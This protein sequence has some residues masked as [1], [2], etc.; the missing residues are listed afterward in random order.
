MVLR[1]A[2]VVALLA[3]FAVAPAVYRRRQARLQRGPDS[4]PPVPSALREGAA[5]TWVV[6]TTPWCASCGPVEARLRASDPDARVV[7]VDATR[8]PELAGAFSVKSAPTVVLADADGR[9]QARLVGSEA[10]ER[11]VSASL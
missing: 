2:I 10:V 3:L 8:E 9:V 6:F 4:H 1:V 11:Y 5:R 7:R